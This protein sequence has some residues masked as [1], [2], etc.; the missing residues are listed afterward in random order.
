MADQL[1]AEMAPDG[2]EPMSRHPDW[3][4]DDELYAVVFTHAPGK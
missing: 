1:I 4:G 3:Q 2:F